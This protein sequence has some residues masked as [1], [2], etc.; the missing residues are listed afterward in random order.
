[1]IKVQKVVNG[2]KKNRT[3]DSCNKI[4][5]TDNYY[6]ILIGEAYYKIWLMRLC[7]DCIEEFHQLLSKDKRDSD[8]L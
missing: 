5:L 8:V 7:D 2:E 1:M 4:L 3:C 6:Q